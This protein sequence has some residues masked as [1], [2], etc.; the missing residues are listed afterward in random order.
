[1]QRR[2]AEKANNAKSEFIANMSHE[3]RTPLN[4]ILGFSELLKGRQENDKYESYVEGILSGGKILLGVI[5]NILDLS[6]I[7]AGRLPISLSPVSLRVLSND[8]EA[9]FKTKA[10]NR[11]VQFDIHIE[12]N[13][14]ELIIADEVRL[15]QILLNVV[16]NAVKFTSKGHIKVHI[17]AQHVFSDSG[18]TLT[19]IVSDTGIGIKKDSLD[20]IFDAFVQ[21]DVQTAR[22]YGGTGLGLAISKKLISL[23]GGTIEVES[24]YGMGST[25]SI[26]LPGLYA[27]AS[28][29]HADTHTQGDT[30]G[31]VFE[32]ANIVLIEDVESNRQV[33]QGL[34][35][36]TG[37]SIHEFETGKDALRH[38]V[39]LNPDLFLVDIMLPDIDGFE[40]HS[41]IRS[42]NSFRTTPVILVSAGL[43]LKKEFKFDDNTDFLPKP[44]KREELVNALKKYLPVKPIEPYVAENKLPDTPRLKSLFRIAGSQEAAIKK[45]F[46]AQCEKL[47]ELSSNDDILALA[48][49]VMHYAS[50]HQLDAVLNWAA[51]LQVYSQNFDI[52]E[53][54]NMFHEFVE[55][56]KSGHNHVGD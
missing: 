16:G 5:N 36:N 34:L 2:D 13:V 8:L 30:Q 7:E 51:Q 26:T 10:R 43:R 28:R 44:F 18:M 50:A 38:A 52:E 42:D 19:I 39:K 55:Y 48:S 20:K 1:M 53:M 41:R 46:L 4:A 40:V 35:E 29:K 32:P 17:K 9:L 22:Q 11:S 45:Q 12:D 25:F 54:N 23:M 6:K 3:I 47:A 31:V 14:P 56:L 49:D 21:Q 37:L 24:E 27:V 33:I 15:R